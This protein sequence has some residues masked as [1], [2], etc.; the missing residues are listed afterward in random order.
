MDKF[1][2]PKY[3]ACNET[4]KVVTK[5]DFLLTALPQIQAESCV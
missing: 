4:V 5:L 1:F 2:H 3:V